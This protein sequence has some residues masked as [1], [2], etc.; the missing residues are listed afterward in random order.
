MKKNLFKIFGIIAIAAIIGFSMTACDDDGGGDDPRTVTY[1]GEDSDG[2]TYTLVITEKNG[3]Y[4][5]G[6]GDSYKLTSKEKSS[7]KDYVS[8][9]TVTGNSSG[10]VKLKPSNSN[11]SFDVTTS[12]EGITRIEGKIKW[13]NGDVW[14]CQSGILVTPKGKTEGGSDSGSSDSGSGGSGSGGSITVTG[15]PG[16]Y[17]GKW[18]WVQAVDTASKFVSGHKRLD[19]NGNKATYVFSQISGGSVTTS[20][21]LANETSTVFSGYTGSDTFPIVSMGIM[22]EE[23]VTVNNDSEI[24]M[25]F[26]MYIVGV[27]MFSDIKFS[28][29]RVT[30]RWDDG[31]TADYDDDDDDIPP[32]GV[33]GD[34]TH[35]TGWPTSKV[36]SDHGISG[37]PAPA[38]ATDIYWTAVSNSSGSSLSITFTGSEANDDPVSNWF[39][40]NGWTLSASMTVPGIY[41][42]FTKPNYHA[43]YMRDPDEDDDN[44]HII[45][46]WQ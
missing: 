37:M 14:D 17:N 3:R 10:K 21:W 30:L 39:T 43:M 35:G 28:G 5:A 1:K 41:N 34:Y 7:G 36:L 33:G 44:C 23:T 38:G 8:E 26:Q 20:A 11:E 45:V 42:Q 19:I 9:G 31:M 40:D 27:N 22:S 6:T 24:Q 4:T 13:K 18:I 29:G 16:K 32:G 25:S 12:D 46:S 15:I 2:D